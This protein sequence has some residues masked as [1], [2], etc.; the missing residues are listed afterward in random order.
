MALIK[1]R[2][3]VSKRECSR[4][5]SWIFEPHPFLVD[6][7]NSDGDTNTD[8]STLLGIVI[9]GNC[10]TILFFQVKEMSGWLKYVVLTN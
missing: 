6:I 3:A 1:Y 9:W 4:S 7:D 5:P 10:T 8:C 2:K